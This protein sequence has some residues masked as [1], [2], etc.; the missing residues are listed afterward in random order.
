MELILISPSGRKDTE[1]PYLLNMFENGLM[2]YHLRKTRFSTRELRNFIAEIPEKYHNRIV[3]HTHHELARRFNLKGVYISRS[4]KKRRYRTWFN[5]LCTRMTGKKILVSQTVR[6]IESMLDH[7][8]LYD[9]VF[10]SPVFDSLSGNY[11]AAFTEGELRN[12]MKQTKYHTIA[13][14]GI[15]VGTIAEAHK[16]GFKGVAFYSGIWK[17]EKPLE[18]FKKIRDK[19]AELGIPM[20]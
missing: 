8:P 14:G 17:K 11:Q 19:F 18:E 13:R 3:I 9:Y 5:L 4:H 10:L 6:S 1:L 20:E 16:L 15:H 7:H 12:V 2:T